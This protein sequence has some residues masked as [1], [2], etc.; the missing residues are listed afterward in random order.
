MSI[1]TSI[2]KTAGGRRSHRLAVIAAIAAVIALT[3]WATAIY[4]VNSATRPV[5]SNAPT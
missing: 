3:A 5:R 1:S 2:P 4:A